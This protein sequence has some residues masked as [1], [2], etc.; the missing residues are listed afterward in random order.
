MDWSKELDALLRRADALLARPPISREQIEDALDPVFLRHTGKTYR[1][2]V[3]S[4]PS[5]NGNSRGQ[6][7]VDFVRLLSDDE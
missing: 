5:R 6:V 2:Q 7:Q 1:E 3:K 4:D